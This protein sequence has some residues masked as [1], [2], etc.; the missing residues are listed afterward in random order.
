M[1]STLGANGKDGR[2]IAIPGDEQAEAKAREDLSEYSFFKYAATYFLHNI[3][4]SFSRKHL[5]ASLLKLPSTVD[6]ISSQ[7]IWITVLRFMGDIAEAK[8]DH[9][10]DNNAEHSNRRVPIMQKLN[11]TLNKSFAKTG[12]FKAFVDN[13][14]ETDRRK[15]IQKTLRKKSKLPEEIRQI[16]ESSGELNVYQ[17]W[18]NVRSSHLDKLHFVIGHGILRPELRD[19]IY[20]QILK[21]L[22]NNPHSISH[23]KGWILLSLCLGC[24]PPSEQFEIYLRSFIRNGPQLYAEYCERRLNRTLLVSWLDS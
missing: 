16:V 7:A 20:C 4:H 14:S 8:F 2:S 3:S 24:F 21:Q 22:T 12:D 11:S 15:L 9:D 19:E 23:T 17:S 18:L 6:E 13:L 5:P 10:D 1:P